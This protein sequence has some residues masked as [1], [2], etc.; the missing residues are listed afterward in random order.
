MTPLS[1]SRDGSFLL[2]ASRAP[3][4]GDDLWAL[5]LR[6]DRKPV[7]IAASEWSETDGA[8]S[9]DGRWV[10]YVSN[11][12]DRREI[13]VR[14]F[15]PS[16]ATGRGVTPVSRGGGSSPR[17][18]VDGKELF[19][20]SANG[21][22]MSVDITP[23]STFQSGPP[24]ALFQLPRGTAFSDTD[25]QGRTLAVVPLQSGTQAPFN[26]VLNWQPGLTP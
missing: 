3:K 12:S 20:V 5:P 22:L 8:F 26:V 17:W 15:S 7:A 16:G 1:W 6:G 23:G 11:D 2:Y 21:T 24:K 13:Y 14:A 18:R 10:A 9:P 19:Y 4:T 25:G